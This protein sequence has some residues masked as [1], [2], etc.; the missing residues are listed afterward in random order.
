LYKSSSQDADKQVKK[1]TCY[2]SE[3]EAKQQ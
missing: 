1:V 3:S 2:R